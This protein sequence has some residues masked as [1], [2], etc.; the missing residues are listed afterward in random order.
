MLRISPH[1]DQSLV[2]VSRAPFIDHEDIKLLR[3]IKKVT[4]GVFK[5]LFTGL[6]FQG[7]KT[8]LVDCVHDIFYYLED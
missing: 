4:P 6:Q 5:K 8:W 3:Y 2:F 7:D 1:Y